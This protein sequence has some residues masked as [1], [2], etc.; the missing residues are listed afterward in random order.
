M[1]HKRTVPR[2][3]PAHAVALFW[4]LTV[5]LVLTAP[6]GLQAAEP[7]AGFEGPADS[8]SLPGMVSEIPDAP[9]TPEA[10]P[11][12]C[13]QQL[14]GCLIAATINLSRC[15]A[16]VPVGD[17]FCWLKYELDVLICIQQAD[18]CASTCIP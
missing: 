15:V 5:V 4:S 6:G 16:S 12:A 8:M 2:P 14:R 17:V 1:R 3:L 9:W 11:C 18:V 7:P 10:D 13:L